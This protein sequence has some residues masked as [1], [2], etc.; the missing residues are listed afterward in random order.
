[1]W[2]IESPLARPSPSIPVPRTPLP[3]RRD[4]ARPREGVPGRPVRSRRRHGAEPDHPPDLA[5]Q[6][7]GDVA[8]LPGTLLQDL[9]DLAGIGDELVVAGPHGAEFRLEQLEELVLRLSPGEALL[10]RA[11]KCRGLFRR[12]EGAVD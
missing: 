7:D 12:G 6:R 1:M 8:R 3:L 4:G 2:S 10:E 9:L 5:H 11:P